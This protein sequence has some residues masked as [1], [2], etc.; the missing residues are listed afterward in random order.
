MRG[1]GEGYEEALTSPGQGR[2]CLTRAGAGEVV[3]GP[4]MGWGG[5]AGPRQGLAT[6]CQVPH[7]TFLALPVL[8]GV[9]AGEASGSLVRRSAVACD[10]PF[11]PC[12]CPAPFAVNGEYPGPL[13]KVKE[14]TRVLITV[15]NE[16]EIPV[17]IHW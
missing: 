9:G 12:L 6:S 15:K 17:T 4:G 8:K 5:G 16:Q 3:P 14:G 10:Q 2:W 1:E 13:V 11:P 7:D